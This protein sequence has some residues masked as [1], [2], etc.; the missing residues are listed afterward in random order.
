MELNSDIAKKSFAGARSPFARKARGVFVAAMALSAALSF[1]PITSVVQEARSATAGVPFRG[2]V[3]TANACTIIIQQNGTFG[4]S[5]NGRV[6][7]SKLAGGVAGVADIVSGANYFISATT[8][9]FFTQFPPL[10]NNNTTFQSTF[11]GQDISRGRTFADQPGTTPVRLRGG[12]STTRVNVHLIATRTGT[13]FP[14]GNYRGV[15][16]VRCE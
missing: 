2:S 14:A 7:S 4:L 3:T 10:G 13:P 5:A 15:V 6:L 11:S 12:N 1:S 9:P 16:V 8:F